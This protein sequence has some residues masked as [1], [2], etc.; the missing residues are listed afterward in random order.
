MEQSGTPDEPGAKRSGDPLTI[1]PAP[2]VEVLSP[3]ILLSLLNFPT[4]GLLKIDAALLF[5]GSDETFAFYW[6]ERHGTPQC[7]FLS[8]NEVRAAFASM[9][10][11]SGWLPPRTLRFG[12]DKTGAQWLCMFIPPAHHELSIMDHDL[13][14]SR[15]VV[16]LPGFVFTGC[17]QRYWIWAVKDRDVTAQ[18]QLFHAPLSNVRADGSICFG[19]NQVPGATGATILQAF[20][21]FLASPFNGHASNQKSRSHPGDV[22]FFLKDLAAQNVPSF[23]VEDLVGIVTQGAPTTVVTLEFLLKHVTLRMV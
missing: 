22:R 19:T 7:K 11:E 8:A 3:D 18:S 14:E 10:F 16:P 12:I 15:I 13:G 23:P 2:L 6:R 1:K 17:G 5:L 20:S 4:G 21:L 9:P